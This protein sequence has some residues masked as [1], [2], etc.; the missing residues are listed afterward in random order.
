MATGKKQ[1]SK[2][3]ISVTCEGADTVDFKVLNRLQGNLK[4][5]DPGE[6]AQLR[7]EILEEGISFPFFLWKDP[8][9]KLWIIDAHQ[10]LTVLEALEKEGWKIP[11]VPVAWI[12][13]KNKKHAMKKIA[14]AASQYGKVTPDGLFGFMKLSG[15]SMSQVS[16]SFRFPEVN[17]T[18]FQA[19][20]FPEIKNV[21]FKAKSGGE[22]SEDSLGEFKHKCPACGHQFDPPA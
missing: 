15:I 4:V 17:L 21:E 6:Q 7:G 19:G 5:M 3:T 11:K 16:R 20:F 8:E 18:K 14:A 9:A 22:I 1:P 2:G 12:H 13:A 10:R